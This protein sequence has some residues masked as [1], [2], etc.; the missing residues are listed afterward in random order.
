[1][2]SWLPLFF[3]LALG[4]ETAVVVRGDVPPSGCD[5]Q[6]RVVLALEARRATLSGVVTLELHSSAWSVRYLGVERT[7]GQVSC[8][9]AASLT[10]AIVVV[11]TPNSSEVAGVARVSVA[12]AGSSGQATRGQAEQSSHAP[13][14]QPVQV[15]HN[16]VLT[17]GEAA[18]RF[19]AGAS[20][21]ESATLSRDAGAV[22]HPLSGESSS[23]TPVEKGELSSAAL[24]EKPQGAVQHSVSGELSSAALA[25]KPQGAVQHQVSGELTRATPASSVSQAGAGTEFGL[26]R[27]SETPLVS[28]ESQSNTGLGPPIENVAHLNPQISAVVGAFATS[29]PSIAGSA[30]LSAG[31]LYGRWSFALSADFALPQ[32][33][34]VMINANRSGTVTSLSFAAGVAAGWCFGSTIVFCPSLTGGVRGLSVAAT[35]TL[36]QQSTA[37]L[38]VGYAGAELLLRWHFA[39]HWALT[40]RV[41]PQLPFGKVQA[42]VEGTTSATS[43]GTVEGSVGLG[44]TWCPGFIF[45]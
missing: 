30:N 20:R 37:V 35:G 15:P 14:T 32:S 10:A 34:P 28:S 4:A 23:A 5:L 21:G 31:L 25:E 42:V 27:A 24:A 45:F 38:F 41:A 6:R 22:Q 2:I 33:L 7:L 12:D 26:D 36:Y 3:Q 40:A 13:T 19:D 39:D 8:E 18:R 9:E 43:T 29:N 11:H 1:M 16:R 44:L 17:A